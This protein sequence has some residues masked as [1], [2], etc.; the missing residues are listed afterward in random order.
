MKKSVVTAVVFG[1]LAT[2]AFGATYAFAQGP[3]QPYPWGGRGG[4]MGGLGYNADWQIKMQ[5]ATAQA[6]GL[7]LD[8]LNAELRAGKTLAQIAQAKKLDPAK[9][10]DAIQV[11][12]KALLQQA[13]KD[14]KLTQVQADAMIARQ[15]AMN[16]Y[17]DANGG[18]RQCGRAIIRKD[19]CRCAAGTARTQ[20]IRWADRAVEC[21]E[22][23][24]W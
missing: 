9:V 2:F 1:V 8:Q 5:E 17:W 15:D 3:T 20:G 24:N 21:G 22:R 12:H 11:A 4:M 18:Y 7:T 23:G 16:K 14:G 6:L 13:V 19:K 10:Y